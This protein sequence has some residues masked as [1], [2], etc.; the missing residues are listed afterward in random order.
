MTQKDFIFEKNKIVTKLMLFSLVLGL[1]VDFVN[2]VPMS[3]ILTLAIVGAIAL[4]PSWLLTYKRIFE[5]AVRY[6]VVIGMA[7]LSFLLIKSHPHTANYILLYYGIA[8]VSI[9][10][11]FKPII[12]IGVINFIL[13]NYFYYQYK[14]VMFPGLDGQKL[15]SLNLYLVLITSVLA[16]QSKIGEKM[17]NQLENKNMEL[18]EDK[19]QIDILMS[20]LSDTLT[21]ISTFS[22]NLMENLEIIKKISEEVANT[23]HEIANSIESQSHSITDINQSIIKSNDEI[24]LVTKA[25]EKMAQLSQNTFNI[26]ENGSKKV[27]SL[28][29]EIEEVNTSMDTTTA[30]LEELNQQ[31]EQISIILKSINE[32]A[33]Q[34][35][36]LAL[37]AAIEAA[38]AGDHGK[39]FA[40]V[41]E[42]IR[43]LAENSSK[44]T[45]E[46]SSILG[47]VQLKTKEVTNKVHKD[48]ELFNSSKIATND[49][50]DLFKEI[51]ENTNNV[52]VQADDVKQK[53]SKVHKN[54][55]S[56]LNEIMAITGV[57]EENSAAVEE[58]AANITEEDSRVEEIINSFKELEVLMTKLREL[59]E[60][61]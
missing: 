3:T 56:I 39:G 43:N 33:E 42:E 16:F 14:D 58:V 36:L 55:E 51:N 9:F 15:I 28:T 30:I 60:N 20:Q 6:I 41:A 27:V 40:V 50:Y 18:V 31:S 29:N 26:A 19:A 37:N 46:I 49:V 34:T 5:K 10:Q 21:T 44:F 2:K 59:L 13:T 38:R 8:V 22:L 54:S 4:I 25:A 11:D 48:Q 12:L 53:I 32:I 7:S 61:N 24:Q 45:E 1:I 35:N 17:T 23:S 52:L 57:T 47:E